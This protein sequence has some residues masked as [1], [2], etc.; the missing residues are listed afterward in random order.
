MLCG[1]E[2]RGE[3]VLEGAAWMT[4]LSSNASRIRKCTPRG[5]KRSIPLGSTCQSYQRLQHANSTLSEHTGR[6]IM[7]MHMSQRTRLP[8]CLDVA[9]DQEHT[10]GSTPLRFSRSMHPCGVQETNLGVLPPSARLPM[11]CGLLIFEA[12]GSPIRVGNAQKP[13]FG[14]F[15]QKKRP[16]S[17]NI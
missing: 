4:C 1:G 2:Q 9:S 16:K 12:L 6:I 11:F 7:V 14:P 3:S 5:Q 10:A 8:G 17:F 15:S 13:I